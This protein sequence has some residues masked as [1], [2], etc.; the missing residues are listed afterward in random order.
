MVVDLIC[1][2]CNK[3]FKSIQYLNQHKN[4]RYKCTHVF[5]CEVCDKIF[6]THRDLELHTN[7]KKKCISITT[8][9]KL[10]QIELE[11]T[12]LNIN[13]EILKIKE[14]T[15]QEKEKT[16]RKR[17]TIKARQEEEAR[18][19]AERIKTEADKKQSIK[20]KFEQ[21]LNTIINDTECYEHEHDIT[22]VKEIF[23]NS[24]NHKMFQNML[25]KTHICDIL[26]EII[27]LIYSSKNNVFY[28]KQLMKYY[29]IK[30]LE[31][32][33]KSAKKIEYNKGL[34]E[35]VEET[36]EFVLENIRQTIS[37]KKIVDEKDILYYNIFEFKNILVEIK[38][39][40]LKGLEKY[41]S[42]IKEY[43]D[44]NSGIKQK[45]QSLICDSDD[46]SD[47]E[48]EPI[49]DIVSKFRS[50]IQKTFT[51]SINLEL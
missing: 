44:H 29:I 15:V 22:R 14:Q 31:N 8:E 13:A 28:L 7:R 5:S 48:E 38:G 51:D 50:H 16:L 47:N 43:N 11:M 36:I 19:E 2:D 1:K 9:L 10:K 3:E 45:K 40:N 25:D 35:D 23:R 39:K 21:Y 34:Q 24:D 20:N 49:S 4:R 18:I 41:A 27:K 6:K 42:F 26:N 33:T 37:D 32:K 17:I 12:K 46:E 30:E